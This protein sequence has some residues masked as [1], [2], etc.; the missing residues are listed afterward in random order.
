MTLDA[1][2]HAALDGTPHGFFTRKGGASSGVYAGLNCGSGSQDMAEVVEINRTRVAAAMGVERERLVGVHQ[3]HSPDVVVAHGPLVD[4]PEAD[5]V[6]TATPGLAL[7]VLTADCG[8]VLF[9]DRNA[10]VVG[11]AHAGWKGAM[12][13]VLEATLEAME[14]LG[15]RRAGIRAVLGP[16]I[17]QANYEVGQEFLDR[18]LAE[19]PDNAGFFTAGQAKGKHQFDLPAYCLRRLEAAGLGEAVWTGD[20]TYADPARFYSFRRSVHRQEADYGR[21]IAAIRL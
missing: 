13:G 21:L 9:A 10:G 18:F 3:V 1:I 8:P 15:A 7:S 4:K 2:T 19:D 20:C 11:A 12:G 17:S 5:A 14:T 16:T 6:V